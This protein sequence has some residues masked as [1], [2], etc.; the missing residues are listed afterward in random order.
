MIV[1]QNVTK[2]IVEL[3]CIPFFTKEKNRKE[4]KNQKKLEFKREKK[5]CKK[6]S[7]IGLP[8]ILFCT[9]CV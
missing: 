4:M 7:Y 9:K 8:C 6:M 1:I 3:I 5:R 2:Y